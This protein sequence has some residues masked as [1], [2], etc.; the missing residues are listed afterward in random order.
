MHIR[1]HRQMFKDKR[2][3]RRFQQLLARFRLYRHAVRP[4]FYRRAVSL[5]QRLIVVLAHSHTPLICTRPCST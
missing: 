2:H 4:H 5:R 3:L 1:H